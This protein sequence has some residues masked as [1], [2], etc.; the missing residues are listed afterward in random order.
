MIL[1]RIFDLIFASIL[2]ITL[3]PLLIIIAMAVKFNSKGSVFYVQRRIGKNGSDFNLFKFR[4]MYE[5]SDRAGLLTIGYAD[6]RIT[7]VGHW[8]RKYKLDELPQLINIIIGDMSFVGPRPE[9]SKYVAI[10]SVQQLRVL[11]VKPGLTDWAS[12][13]YFNE[14][15]LLATAEDPEGL[16]VN[17]ILPSK[18]FQNLE[19]ID[20]RNFLMDIRIILSTLKRLLK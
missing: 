19:Y 18:I 12:I 15:E 8:L 17:T 10:Y 2:L 7:T 11:S 6:F 1:K 4:T 9:V 20:N 16:Y 13:K 5:F 14:N 3:T